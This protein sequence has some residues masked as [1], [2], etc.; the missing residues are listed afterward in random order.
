MLLFRHQGAALK[1]IREGQVYLTNPLFPP[2][3]GLK[4]R[5]QRFLSNQMAV[6]AKSSP[7][8]RELGA[9]TLQ[10]ALWPSLAL[11][12]RQHAGAIITADMVFGTNT[13]CG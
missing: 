12:S 7:C 8:R 6:L 4:S 1:V 10:I 11:Y 3:I 13:G 5:Y 2:R 9:V